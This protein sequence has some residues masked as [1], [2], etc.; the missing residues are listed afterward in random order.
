MNDDNDIIFQIAKQ[1]SELKD[2][3]YTIVF[4][5]KAGIPKQTITINMNCLSQRFSHIIGLEHIKDFE[6]FNIK[7]NLSSFEKDRRRSRIFNKVLAKDITLESL[8]QKSKMFFNASTN[9]YYS[10]K[11]TVNPTTKKPYTI[12]E[13]L[14]AIKNI[15][16]I[17]DTSLSYG[18]LYERNLS[19]YMMGYTKIPALYVIGIPTSNKSECLYFF[20]DN[21]STDMRIITAFSDSAQL[22]RNPKKTYSVLKIDK[23]K[24]SSRNENKEIY[25]NPKYASFLRANNQTYSSNKTENMRTNSY[26]IPLHIMN[27]GGAAAL[28]SPLFPRPPFGQAVRE[29]LKDIVNKIKEIVEHL[30]RKS[31]QDTAGTDDTNRGSGNSLRDSAPKQADTTSLKS[32]THELLEKDAPTMEQ[33]QKPLVKT[34]ATPRKT[35]SQGLDD[36]S[37]RFGGRSS[38]KPPLHNNT[39]HKH[40]K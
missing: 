22:F 1:F 3:D 36:L 19:D 17:F 18:K 11:N 34:A 30:L 29:F 7:D 15:E 23:I 24:R 26:K 13:R 28:A 6:D 20:L 2:Y 31:D 38:T 39:D 35:F 14:N 25:I 8:K 12:I 9:E 32:E 21:N 10:F 27:Q 5:T 4:G 37:R 16:S 33:S 40:H